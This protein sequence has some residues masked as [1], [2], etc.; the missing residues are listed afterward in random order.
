MDKKIVNNQRINVVSFNAS[1]EQTNPNLLNFSALVGYV[2]E[3]SDGTPCGGISGYKVIL[4]GDDI[5]VD[6]LKGSGVNC[7]WANDWFSSGANNLKG[8]NTRFKIGVIDNA[9]IEGNEI[10]AAGHLWK[11]DFPDICD[12]IE[13]AKDSLGCSVEA[14][15]NGVKRD[16]I[17]K[18]LTCSGVNF[19]GLAI[20][21]KS[22]AAFKNTSFM[23]SLMNDNKENEDLDKNEIQKNVDEAVSAKFSEMK[24]TQDKQF[25]ELKDMVA[26]FGEKH[27]EKKLENKADDSMNFADF[28]KN[29]TDAI[30]AGFAASEA[31][32]VN[33]KVAD[34]KE[35]ATR[36][37]H[38]DF[39]SIKQFDGNQEPKNVMQLA[40]EIDN[41]A[42]LSESE[43]WAKKLK[44]WGEYQTK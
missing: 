18:T 34:Q 44:I 38:V 23:C 12:T 1:P 24:E 15:Y 33:E 43:K 22:K 21:Y 8:H 5:D 17:A 11:N 42:S 26:K 16:D 25:N 32:A 13:C 29:I 19:T 30:K 41:D 39:S 28:A 40:E 7:V 36:K 35:D 9:W 27:E 37:T 6:S 2:N 31:Q 20:L 3:P 10:H 4:S 14:S